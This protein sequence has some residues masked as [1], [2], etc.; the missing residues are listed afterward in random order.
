MIADTDDARLLR[1]YINGSA[2]WHGTA[3][4]RAVVETARVLHLAGASVF[5]VEASFGASG[6]LRDAKSDYLFADVPVV[7]EV[8]DAS[9]RIEE[10]LDHLR[11]MIAD[12]FAT[13]EPVRVIRY[14]HHDERLESGEPEQGPLREATPMAIEG[15]AQRV[16]VYLGS[17]DTWNGRNLATAIV[18]RCRQSGIAGATASLG[19][20]GFGKQSRAAPP[21]APAGTVGRPARTDRDR[22]PP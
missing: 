2:R 15:E 17:S 6:R 20:M 1:I 14:A 9:G 10:L 21:G 19:V 5:L 18:E 8:V 16:T 11:P 12:E 3:L 22:R 7:V 4:Y 13:L